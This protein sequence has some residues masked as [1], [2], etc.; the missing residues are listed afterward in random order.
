M[1]V[2][3]VALLC[4]GVKQS[5][6]QSPRAGVIIVCVCVALFVTVAVWT[7]VLVQQSKRA[8]INTAD[9]FATSLIPAR[10]FSTGPFPL[11]SMP[12]V[13]RQAWD[14]WRFQNMHMSYLD[15]V[16]AAAFVATHFP[17]YE[18]DFDAVVP[19]A[20]RADMLRL[21]LLLYHGG[22]YVDCGVHT[23]C[24]DFQ[25]YL[26]DSTL[27]FADDNN[28][29]AGS[30]FQGVL[31]AVPGHPWIAAAVRLVMD[32]VHRRVYGDHCLDITGPRAVGR[33]FLSMAHA[34]HATSLLHPNT[35]HWI[36]GHH[37]EHKVTILQYAT[38]AVVN[39]HNQPVL[40]TKV[41]KYYALMYT[42]RHENH[43]TKLW[44][45]RQVYKPGSVV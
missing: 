18:K 14:S 9:T 38:G 5:M 42:A 35:G 4:T 43:Y 41:D 10:L 22:L 32:N 29:M 37:P 11:S 36:P 24:R 31:A 25:K 34:S 44:A 19:G 7:A 6:Q 16:D 20:F 12:P 27:V 13:L 40:H 45:N 8:T 28:A 2:V 21:L 30:V 17:Q 3:V 26:T 33:A 15:D 39:D 1:V 23:V